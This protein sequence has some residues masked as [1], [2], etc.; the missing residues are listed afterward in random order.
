MKNIREKLKS[1]WVLFIVI[2][3]MIYLIE[4]IIHIINIEDIRKNLIGKS[5]E[6][7]LG[8]YAALYFKPIFDLLV[9]YYFLF[10][11]KIIDNKILLK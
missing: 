4:N 5:D 3:Y 9:L 6:Y 10:K 2:M 11:I 1:K 7:K 8:A